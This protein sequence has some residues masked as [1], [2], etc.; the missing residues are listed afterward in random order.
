MKLIVKK[1]G[2]IV[3]A[4]KAEYTPAEELIINNAMRRFIEDKEV[5]GT[6]KTLMQQMLEIE[7]IFEDAAEGK[8]I[9]AE[10][11]RYEI[12]RKGQQTTK[13]ALLE[14]LAQEDTQILGLA[15]AQAKYMRTYGIDITY[16]VYTATQNIE[17]ISNAYQ[18][19]YAD[20]ME[21]CVNRQ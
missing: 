5:N 2:N 7:P 4:I 6:D 8:V 17:L 13:D 16:A 15:Y 19:G 10:L 14:L 9:D 20:A 21:K 12:P 11:I 18:K 3:K 1:Q